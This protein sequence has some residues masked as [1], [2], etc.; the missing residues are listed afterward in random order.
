MAVEG[1][2]WYVHLPPSLLVRLGS[3]MNRLRKLRVIT[4]KSQS[5]IYAQSI[6]CTNI[7]QHITAICG[8]PN[9]LK[10]LLELD[11]YIINE[12]DAFGNSVLHLGARV[13]R[14]NVCKEMLKYPLL[15]LRGKTTLGSPH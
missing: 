7:T 1:I 8:C 6:C 4:D 11:H 2:H 12:T 14:V 9:V 15:D 3:Q 10:V 13:G 5:I